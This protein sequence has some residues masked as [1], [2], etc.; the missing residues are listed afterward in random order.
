MKEG[1][2]VDLRIFL[3]VEPLLAAYKITMF[4]YAVSRRSLAG[5]TP[6]LKRGTLERFSA[7]SPSKGC[8]STERRFDSGRSRELTVKATTSLANPL[9]VTKTYRYRKKRINKENI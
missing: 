5:R 7:V 4:L 3:T 6:W 9:R 8:G 2:C 1:Y